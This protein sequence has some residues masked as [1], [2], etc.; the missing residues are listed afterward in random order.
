MSINKD[1]LIF[2]EDDIQSSDQVGSHIIGNSGTKVS[3]TSINSTKEA[4]DVAINGLY[5]DE[6]TTTFPDVT[7]ELYTY[8]KNSTTVQTVLVTYLDSTKKTIVSLQKTRF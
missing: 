4:I 8:K 3:S 1:Q 6:I 7:Q 2:D 5:W